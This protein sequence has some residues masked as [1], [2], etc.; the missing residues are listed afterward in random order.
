MALFVLALLVGEPWILLPN[1]GAQVPP[2]FQT[3]MPWYTIEPPI[4]LT[5][6][7]IPPELLNTPMQIER[8]ARPILLWPPEGALQNLSGT[9]NLANVEGLI[10]GARTQMLTFTAPGANVFVGD[11]TKYEN[12]A[13]AMGDCYRAHEHPIYLVAAAVLYATVAIGYRV[14]ADDAGRVN[15]VRA[16]YRDLCLLVDYARSDDVTRDL[17]Q[18]HTMDQRLAN[19]VGPDCGDLPF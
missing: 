5:P 3:P 8:V 14:M 12:S 11:Y 4:Q 1:V 10:D 13:H 2:N 7:T 16:S 17:H 19:N 9:C 15:N 18:S 6:A